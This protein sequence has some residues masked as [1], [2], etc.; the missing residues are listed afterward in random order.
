MV[1]S[2]RA[3]CGIAALLF[4]SSA[5]AADVVGPPPSECPDGHKATTDHGGPY[6]KPPAPKSCPAGQRPKV[7]RDQAYCEPAPSKGCPP[8]SFWTSTSATDTYC[9]A[10]R[11]CESSACAA[12]MTCRDTALCLE[13]RH[14]GRGAIQV[15]SGACE[16]GAACGK[17]K[18]VEAKRCA[19][20]LVQIDPSADPAASAAPSAS[21]SASASGS[22]S[23]AAS[24]SPAPSASAAPASSSTP[25]PAG[26]SGCG[27]CALRTRSG[28]SP[29]APLALLG[30]ALAAVLRRRR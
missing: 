2:L 26:Q 11:R 17:G 7:V 19:G 10:S 24:G 18:C 29:A 22:A 6:C 21:A 12:G 25:P 23:A 4:W 28:G 14:F 9:Q 3:V 15:V 8:G 30:L 16:G 27:G 5:A 20:D 13:Y 1:S